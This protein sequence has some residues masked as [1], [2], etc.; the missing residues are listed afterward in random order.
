MLPQQNKNAELQDAARRNAQ[1]MPQHAILTGLP[2]YVS[3]AALQR[4]PADNHKHAETRTWR[5]CSCPLCHTR[6]GASGGP[7]CG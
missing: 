4:S 7:A 6:T 2:D 3:R 5:P 1:R